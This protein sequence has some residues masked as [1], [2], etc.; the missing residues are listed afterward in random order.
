MWM[1]MLCKL[2]EHYFRDAGRL[3]HMF[4]EPAKCFGRSVR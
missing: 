3:E 4:V 1:E 2:D